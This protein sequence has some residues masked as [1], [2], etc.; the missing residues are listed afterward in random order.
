MTWISAPEAAC[1]TETAVDAVEA[2]ISPQDRHLAGLEISR[3]LPTR[4]RRT[5]GPF[6]FL[7]RFGPVE[8]IRGASLEVPPHPHIGL[9]TV[10]YLFEGRI[11]HR[12]S[13]GSA[14]VIEPGD[15]N[16]MTAGRGI[17]HSERT[18][19][20]G[21]SDGARLYGLQSWVALPMDREETEPDFAH[22]DSAILPVEEGDGIWMR[23]ILGSAFGSK[24]PVA[25][26]AEPVYADCKIRA[27][28]SLKVPAEI[29]ERSVLVLSGSVRAGGIEIAPGSLAVFRRD[30]ELVVSASS[31]A[32][33]VL[34]GGARL[35]GPR[36]VWWNFVSSSRE[37]IE[38]AKTQWQK[39]AFPSVP[40]DD[41]YVPLPE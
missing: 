36:H 18:S 31:D 5:I 23:L 15:V 7:D 12:D 17:V 19:T 38:A 26:M 2:L 33:V 4:K 20:A 32:H 34:M 29:E 39:H 11:M 25:V 30:V 16:W 13:L 24:S 28:A 10:T 3:L 37:R 9:A 22:Y 27:G 6:A 8:L 14:R 35:D 1:I 21:N 40:G 41:G